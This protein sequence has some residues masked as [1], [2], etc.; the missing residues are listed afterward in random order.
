MQRWILPLFLVVVSVLINIALQLAQRKEK[1]QG[2]K[3]VVVV[4]GSYVGSVSRGHLF[5]ANADV[6]YHGIGNGHQACQCPAGW[7]PCKLTRPYVSSI[8]AHRL[9]RF[10]SSNRIAISTISSHLFVVRLGS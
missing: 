5:L 7:I 8:W 9:S 3:N 6:N 4:G 2:L 1:M 10:F